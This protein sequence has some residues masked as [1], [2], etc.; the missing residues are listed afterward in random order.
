M[1]WGGRCLRSS[2]YHV[3]KQC[4]GA[5][6]RPRK[7]VVNIQLLPAHA[8]IAASRTNSVFFILIFFI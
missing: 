3:L 5:V 1:G 6:D 4:E 2:R 7:S 8:E